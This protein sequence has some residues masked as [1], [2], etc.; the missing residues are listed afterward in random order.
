LDGWRTV[1]PAAF[2]EYILPS[3]TQDG[4]GKRLFRLATLTCARIEL[5]TVLADIAFMLGRPAKDNRKPK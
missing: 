2:T 5:G 4:V 1:G 3:P